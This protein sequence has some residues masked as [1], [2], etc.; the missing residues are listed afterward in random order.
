MTVERVGIVGAGQ[1]GNG[2]AHVFALAGYEVLMTDISGD[3]LQAAVDLID[4]NLDRQVG[5][6]A[7]ETVAKAESMRRIGTTQ[8]LTDLGQTDLIIL[9]RKP[10]F[11]ADDQ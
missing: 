1:M 2:I 3:A 4:R 6:G 5:K 11:D 7:I 9:H 10:D 8:T